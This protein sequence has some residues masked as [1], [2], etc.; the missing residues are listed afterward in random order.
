MELTLKILMNNLKF[1]V[2]HPHFEIPN[3]EMNDMMVPKNF[4]Y[5]QAN[6]PK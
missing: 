3:F 4:C 1:V 6:G 2:N 5:A